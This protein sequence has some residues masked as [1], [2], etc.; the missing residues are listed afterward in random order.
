MTGGYIR[1][2]SEYKYQLASD[3]K[4]NIHILPAEDIVTEFIEL[5]TSGE[6][7]ETVYMFLKCVRNM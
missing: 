1:Y 7:T 4:I 2:R 3:Y 5:D 6:L